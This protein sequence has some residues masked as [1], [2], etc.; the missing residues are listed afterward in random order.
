VIGAT[1]VCVLA[2]IVALTWLALA[3]GNYLPALYVGGVTQQT[4]FAN[5]I[6]LF[7]WCW[8]MTVVG[9]IFARRRTILDLWLVVTLFAWMPNFLIAAVVTTVRFSLGWYSARIFG[10]IASCT[11]LAVLLTETTVLYARLANA[12]TLLRRERANR[13]MSLDAATS[14]IVH[15]IR[16]P[17]T[18]IGANASAALML[19]EKTPPEIDE[20]RSSLTDI[21]H[22]TNRAENIIASVRDLFRKKNE[23]QWQ[24]ISINDVAQTILTLLQ[25][26]IRA[27]GISIVTEYEEVPP[28]RADRTQLEQVIFNLVRNALEAMIATPRSAARYLR[29]TTRL[30]GR[31]GVVLSVEDSGRGILGEN[32]DRLFEPF[33]T[34][35]LAGT[36]LGLAISRTIVEEH[37]GSL[38]LTKTGSNGTVF[39]INLPLN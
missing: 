8:G 18:T 24:Q 33:F 15:E 6:N 34:T 10:L 36:G 13:L 12:V 30:N 32:R 35:K 14:A 20:A 16:Q 19:L 1:V 21:G 17:L 3:R 2:V 9:V 26:D 5:N 31:S 29:V 28:L 25:P 4:A 27:N 23:D 11:V 39:E 7:M 37:G 38:R 22:A